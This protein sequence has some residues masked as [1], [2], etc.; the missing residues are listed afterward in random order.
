MTKLKY[1]EIGTRWGRLVV[2]DD[3]GQDRYGKAQS[4]L[5]CD[6]G[7]AIFRPC[8]DILNG[9]VRSCGCLKDELGKRKMSAI[10]EA[11]KRRA[12]GR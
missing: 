8:T 9:K 1:L 10:L 12:Q 4:L 2:L 3:G 6:C 11:R 5:H 7:S